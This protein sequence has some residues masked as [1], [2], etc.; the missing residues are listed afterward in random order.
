MDFFTFCVGIFLLF[1]AYNTSRE[2]KKDS[3]KHGLPG[4]FIILGITS[5]I[6]SFFMISPHLIKIFF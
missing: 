2:A 4:L 5:I 1:L 3:S 6:G